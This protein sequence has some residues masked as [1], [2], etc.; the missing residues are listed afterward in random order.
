MKKEGLTRVLVPPVV[1]YVCLIDRFARGHPCIFGSSGVSLFPFLRDALPLAASRLPAAGSVGEV[2]EVQEHR[3][4]SAGGLR[5][6]V[7]TGSGP[8]NYRITIQGV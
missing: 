8:G 3:G 7:G 4:R 2:V 1:L 5:R 6:R